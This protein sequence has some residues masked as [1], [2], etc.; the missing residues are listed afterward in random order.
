M[1]KEQKPGEGY[2]S[3]FRR[4]KDPSIF[5]VV[6]EDTA[7]LLGI[8][9][10]FLGVSLAVAFEAPAIDGIASCV[11][12][13]ILIAVAILLVYESRGLILGESA[14]ADVV[15]SVR[16]LATSERSVQGVARLLTMQLGPRHVLLNMD[17]QFRSD[18]SASALF[19]AV[20]GLEARIRQVHP[21]IRSIFLE[22][23]A[24]RGDRWPKR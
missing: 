14:D 11:I 3:T 13:A 5:I 6:A 9:T 1:L 15:R 16:K 4:S 21:E 10:A 22:I 2:F 7:A 20:D 23:Q 24:L 19:E 8:V 18:I 17:I 12:G